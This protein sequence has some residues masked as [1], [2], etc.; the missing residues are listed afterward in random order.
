MNHSDYENFDFLSAARVIRTLGSARGTAGVFADTVCALYF[1]AKYGECS[2]EL[3][4]ECLGAP[5]SVEVQPT[6]KR[7]YEYTWIGFQSIQS[8]T[9]FVISGSKV[10]GVEESLAA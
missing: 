3:V 6:G 9:R 5:D 4:E 10:V 7:I 2:A 1:K 8:K